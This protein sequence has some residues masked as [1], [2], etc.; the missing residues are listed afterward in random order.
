[1]KFQA[2]N[3]IKY[4]KTKI[5]LC[6]LDW[7]FRFLKETWS[8]VSKLFES[9]FQ[10]KTIKSNPSLTLDLG[11][12]HDKLQLIASF[13]NVLNSI[14]WIIFC[15]CQSGNTHTTPTNGLHISHFYLIHTYYIPGLTAESAWNIPY[16]DRKISPFLY[17]ILL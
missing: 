7:H 2:L 9:V 10:N 4:L 5:W 15:S 16:H 11:H 17:Q 3:L 6:Y 1:M 12:S 13:S 8:I 14:I